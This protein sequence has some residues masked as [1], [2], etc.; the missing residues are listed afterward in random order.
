M[1]ELQSISQL[2]SS[3]PPSGTFCQVSNM[4]ACEKR[5]FDQNWAKIGPKFLGDALQDICEDKECILVPVG[6]Y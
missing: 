6:G 4:A 1:S 5:L 2:F 3:N